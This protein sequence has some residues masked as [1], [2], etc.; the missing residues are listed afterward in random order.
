MIYVFLWLY[1]R[2]TTGAYG[3][4]YR[5]RDNHTGRIVAIKKVRIPL[6]DNGVPMS[7]LREIAL[8]KQL[9]ASDHP[10]IVK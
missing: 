10:N 6:T 3:T 2:P 7:T 5:A 4:V 9:N 1:K 8:L